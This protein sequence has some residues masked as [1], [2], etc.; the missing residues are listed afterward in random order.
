MPRPARKARTGECHGSLLMS[1][2]G[3]AAGGSV[4]YVDATHGAALSAAIRPESLEVV[5]WLLENASEKED[6]AVLRRTSRP[7]PEGPGGQAKAG[8]AV[9]AA[10]ICEH[11]R[12]LLADGPLRGPSSSVRVPQL[13]RSA[14]QTHRG[15]EYANPACRGRCPTGRGS[16]GQRRWRRG[17]TLRLDTLCFP[18]RLVGEVATGVRSW[19]NRQ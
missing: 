17:P 14:S 19:G 13:M 15:D 12:G 18:L 9:T 2:P 3:V 8:S 1:A 7:V 4:N 6:P 5:R 16:V 10:S 11:P